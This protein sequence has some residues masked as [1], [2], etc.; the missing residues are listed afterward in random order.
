LERTSIADHVGDQ[1]LV[2]RTN[3]VDHNM[4][5]EHD[6]CVHVLGDVAEC[7]GIVCFVVVALLNVLSLKDLT[8]VCMQGPS[9]QNEH[10]AKKH[11]GGQGAKHDCKDRTKNTTFSC[12]VFWAMH[13]IVLDSDGLH[14]RD[15]PSPTCPDGHVRL[16][17]HAAALN[18]RDQFIREGK[19]AKIQLPAV[20]GSDGVGT[21]VEAPTR[22]DI[23]GS[24]ML[25]YPALQWGDDPSA[26]GSDF[27]V[28]GM[29]SQGTFAEEIVVPEH[30]VYPCPEHLSDEQAAALPLAGLT[31]YRALITQAFWEPGQ[32]VLITG[33][34]GGVASM[35]LLFATALG[36]RTI[37]TSTSDAKLA[38]AIELGA[39]AG[40]NVR[41]EGWAKK[42]QALGPIDC[43]VDSVGGETINDL[44]SI[45][46][47]GG[48]IVVYGATLGHV[49][50]FNMSKMFW[51]QIHL[52]GSTMGTPSEFEDMVQLVETSRLTPAV[53]S[54]FPLADAE[55]A[56]DR[57][58]AAEQ[59]GK[60]VLRCN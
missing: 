41:T 14:L 2:S 45:I 13:A 44:T 20:L 27:S 29:P 18:H 53:D 28:L 39:T 8:T 31:G 40:V 56:F 9:A 3:H 58:I 43:I 5:L 54:V 36:A 4:V 26:Q 7:T 49:P 11:D 34:G 17:I 57:M 32:T 33:I 42:V 21:V 30:N 10:E 22:P 60:I 24:R 50:M 15:I 59:F 52:V 25:I 37:V 1:G 38:Q 47:P 16:R 48:R 23:V 55:R 46:R 51:K 35:T 12:S 19:Y 6:R